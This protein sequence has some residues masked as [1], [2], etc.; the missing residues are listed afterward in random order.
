MVFDLR[1]QVFNEFPFA[2][3]KFM[4]FSVNIYSF[5]IQLSIFDRNYYKTLVDVYRLFPIFC[6][7]RC[8]YGKIYTGPECVLESCSAGNLE[9]VAVER[10]TEVVREK[11]LG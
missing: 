4:P 10:E 3:R 6:L 2:C 1:F 9:D 5:Q 7:R 11:Q 8:G